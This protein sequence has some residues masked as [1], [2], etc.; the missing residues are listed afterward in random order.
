MPR[1]RI[2]H[3]QDERPHTQ[4]LCS[5]NANEELELSLHTN[6][7]C[8]GASNY[9]HLSEKAKNLITSWH[10]FTHTDLMSRSLLNTHREQLA[11][12]SRL[13]MSDFQSLQRRSLC[14]V[15]SIPENIR[16]LITLELRTNLLPASLPNAS[17]QQKPTIKDGKDAVAFL[18]SRISNTSEQIQVWREAMLNATL[19]RY[20][21][22]ELRRVD[23]HQLTA[24]SLAG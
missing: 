5:A 1:R 22:K 24:Y 14:T 6:F 16:R 3:L 11:R 8:S 20:V 18:R 12:W 23:T 19:L 13:P 2:R 21:E 17:L 9:S 15:S 10:S 4:A 7:F